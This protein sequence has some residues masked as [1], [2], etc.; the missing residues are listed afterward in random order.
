VEP[1][2]RSGEAAVGVL[3]FAVGGCARR[4]LG[5]VRGATCAGAVGCNRLPMPSARHVLLSATRT[6]P[7]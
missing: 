1:L 3:N 5:Q 4:L 2:R 6:A 7:S